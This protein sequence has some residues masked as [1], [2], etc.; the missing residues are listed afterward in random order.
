MTADA[1]QSAVSGPRSAEAVA[2]ALGDGSDHDRL[3]TA[4]LEDELGSGRRG[5]YTPPRY[6]DAGIEEVTKLRG[7]ASGRG[8]CA[9]GP[10]AGCEGEGEGGK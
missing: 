5:I 10:C 9:A 1:P 2:V 3:A 8:P 6:V 4:F 7:E